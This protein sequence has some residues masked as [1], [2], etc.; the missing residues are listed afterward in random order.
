[1]HCCVTRFG[2]NKIASKFIEETVS[3]RIRD[4]SDNPG[5]QKVIYT[6]IYISSAYKLM[7]DGDLD[8]ILAVSRKNNQTNDISGILLYGHGTFLQVLEGSE[9]DVQALYAKICLDMRHS[10]HIKLLSFASEERAFAGWSMGFKRHDRQMEEPNGFLQLFKDEV[11]LPLN[12]QH[13]YTPRIEKL[14]TEFIASNM[15]IRS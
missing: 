3:F 5:R 10:G 14:I 6:I 13:Q 4:Q 8:E 15:K 7:D 1:M 11:L 12:A 9:P 2:W